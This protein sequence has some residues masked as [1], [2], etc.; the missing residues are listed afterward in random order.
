MT[1]IDRINA[2]L[3]RH[4]MEA[5]RFGTLALNDSHLVFDIRNGRKLRR[6]TVRRIEEFMNRLDANP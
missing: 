4:A 2:F 6:A 5:T 3:D 1:L